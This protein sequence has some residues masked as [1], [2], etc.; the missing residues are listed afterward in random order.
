MEAKKELARRI[1]EDFHS[2]ADAARAAG[3]FR[4]VVQSGEAPADIPTVVIPGGRPASVRVDKLLAQV[5][6][7]ES[8][9]D[10]VRKLKAGA[11]QINGSRHRDLSLR[12]DDSSGE[13]LIQV[14]RN[15]RRVRW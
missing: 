6:L 1:V 13:L 9:G 3:E 10:A 5:G 15:W 4:R 12:L 14:G 7:A 11:V 2:A 8:V